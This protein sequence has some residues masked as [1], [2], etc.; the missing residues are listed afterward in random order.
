MTM[1]SGM[2]AFLAQDRVIWGTPAAEAAAAEA[3][4]RGAERIFIVASRTLHRQTDAIARIRAALGEH[5]VGVFDDCV[6]HTPRESVMA[7]TEAARAA[8]PDLV[9]TIGGGTAIDTVKVMLIALAHDV[10]DAAG[11]GDLHLR[12]NADG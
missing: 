5:C 11:L 4:R 12:A 10:R 3:A 8:R 6:E 1:A 9:L 7:A 2:H